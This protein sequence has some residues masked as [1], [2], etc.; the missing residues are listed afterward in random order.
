MPLAYGWEGDSSDCLKLKLEKASFHP[1]VTK[2]HGL[3]SAQVSCLPFH[4]LGSIFL[5][6]WSIAWVKGYFLISQILVAGN[7]SAQLYTVFLLLH[8]ERDEFITPINYLTH[9]VMKTNAGLAV[10]FLWKNWGII[11]Q[12]TSPSAAEMINSGVIFLLMTVGSGPDPTLGLCLLYDLTALLFGQSTSGPW[13]HT[14]HWIM[15]VIC[16]SL[17]AELHLSEKQDFSW[18]QGFDGFAPCPTDR[19]DDDI[20]RQSKPRGVKMRNEP[21]VSPYVPYEL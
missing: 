7:L 14:F 3:S 17:M 8:V 2:L 1:S 19:A 12:V 11:D 20:E 9:L 10:L 21:A 18:L 13:Y 15:V 6:A 4:I 5:T 16:I